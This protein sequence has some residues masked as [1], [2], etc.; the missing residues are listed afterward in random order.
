MP[1]F[2]S[3]VAAS[4]PAAGSVTVSIPTD[5]DAIVATPHKQNNDGSWGYGWI[6]KTTRSLIGFNIAPLQ[7]RIVEKAEIKLYVADHQFTE[8][9]TIIVAH[10]WE[11]S[12]QVPDWEEG[13]NLFNSFAYCKTADYMV[14]AQEYPT[15]AENP[16]P[17]SRRGAT[18][19]CSVDPDYLTPG[20]DQDTNCPPG[21]PA[22]WNP[23]V[24]PERQRGM[25]DGF[26]A[27]ID[28][29]TM[30]SPDP[31]NITIERPELQDMGCNESIECIKDENPTKPRPST[32]DDCWR[33]VT[34]NVTNDVQEALAIP[35]YVR[36]SWL[37]KRRH[38]FRRG[39][40]HW[41][42]R[43]GAHCNKGPGGETGLFRL[44]GDRGK[45]SSALQPVL[46]V[47]L[48]GTT[49]V[50]IPTPAAHCNAYD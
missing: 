14:P 43:E 8:E 29:R 38:E 24:P 26:R 7:G 44:F 17:M 18:W 37:I 31:Q 4:A 30:I 27:N 41:F 47:Q 13:S 32:V 11:P 35:G 34:I 36:P 48:A 3:L 33:S 15:E 12:Q 22:R 10:P 28:A 45:D 42:S 49:P 39:A 1:T 21:T 40:V 2:L 5:R 46:V 23:I 9:G 6:R 50:V 25:H 20:G 16:D 19:K